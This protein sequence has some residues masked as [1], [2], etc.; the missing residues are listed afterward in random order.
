[1]IEKGNKPEDELKKYWFCTEC[2]GILRPIR[3][4]SGSGKFVVSQNKPEIGIKGGLSSKKIFSGDIVK[5]NFLVREYSRLTNY[6]Q[7]QLI[8]VN[9]PHCNKR[10]VS[11]TFSTRFDTFSTNTIRLSHPEQVGLYYSWFKKTAF[12][13]SS[14]KLSTPSFCSECGTKLVGFE[15]YCM[16]CGTKTEF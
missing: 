5:S 2:K 1:M 7:V 12:S 9:C 11:L 6:K 3:G 16:N 8:A 4:L 14:S 10:T 15:E 13:S